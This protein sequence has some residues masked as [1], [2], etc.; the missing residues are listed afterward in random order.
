MPIDTKATRGMP[1][2]PLATWTYADAVAAVEAAA[3]ARISV[4]DYNANERY[5]AGDHWQDGAMWVG[6]RGNDET[7]PIVAAAVKRQFTPVG[8]I[9]EVLQRVANGLLKREAALT[10][11]PIAP[12][13][14]ESAQAKADTDEADAMT[15]AVS[16][17]WD[18]VTLWERAREAVMR[19]RALTRGVLQVTVAETNLVRAT[20]GT[21]SLPTDLTLTDAFR[22]VTLTC[23]DPAAAA[24]VEEARTMRPVAIA[25]YATTDGA[26]TKRWAVLWTIGPADPAAPV[27][28]EDA[29]QVHIRELR[30]N[31]TTPTDLGAQRFDRLTIAEMHGAL[32]ITEGVRR[33]QAR[34][35]FGESML[36]RGMETSGFR[37]RYIINAEPQGTWVDADPGNAIDVRVFEDGVT[38]WKI[39]EVR[40]LGAAISTE[41][42]G[43]ETG[44]TDEKA[45]TRATPSVTIADPTDPQLTIT[46][47]EHARATILQEC[48]QAHILANGEAVV[49]G[50]SRDVARAD[51]E[52]DLSA[53]KPAVEGALRAILE[54]AIALALAMTSDAEL[55]RVGIG[56]DFLTRFRTVVD[57]HIDAGPLSPD[58]RRAVVEEMK[59]GARGR[60]ETM[61][62]L[63]IEDVDAAITALD[64]EEGAQLERLK[65]IAETMKVVAEIP[66]GSLESAARALEAIGI[67]PKLVR[68]LLPKDTDGVPETG[69]APTLVAA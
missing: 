53:T 31:A 45:P 44:G 54:A 48:K 20:D 23:S 8:V 55:R 50:Y 26:V 4:A 68:A 5:L 12:A 36:V 2:K 22:R 60:R 3:S 67:D 57:C 10:F 42:V 58:E 25:L 37:E 30:E 49:S 34:L 21:T 17:W 63:G 52:N 9:S 18:R 59:A 24:L 38:R 43:V 19:A 47:N 32:L 14:P 39:G 27:R 1:T 46:A 65:K 64:G 40:T 62:A 69:T 6:P 33:Q 61:A 41:L 29:T 11:A 15:A 51:H 13:K 16:L 56:R 28:P 35:D 66:G 7:W